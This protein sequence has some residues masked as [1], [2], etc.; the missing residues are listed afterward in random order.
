MA[1]SLNGLGAS[2]L[3]RFAEALLRKE[4]KQAPQLEAPSED[5]A[6]R[7]DFAGAGMRGNHR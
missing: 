1:E 2:L 5:E 3:P 4:S 7:S 6:H